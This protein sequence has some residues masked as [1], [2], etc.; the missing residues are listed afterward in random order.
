MSD[1]RNDA[2]QR[3]LDEARQRDGALD[4]DGSRFARRPRLRA[5]VELGPAPSAGGVARFDLA[6]DWT[7]EPAER[8]GPPATAS[9]AKGVRSPEDMSAEIA[10]ELGL[11]ATLTPDELASRWR[12]F[13]WRNHPD[14]QSIDG[15][16]RANDRVAIAN[17]LY[18]RARRERAKR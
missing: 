14:R 4:D 16:A 8:P 18:D 10:E 3:A 1:R 12:N 11:G 5:G 17:M 15:R 9:A 2:F 13:I 6:L 7:D